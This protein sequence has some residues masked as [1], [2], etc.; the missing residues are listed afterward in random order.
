MITPL[1][2]QLR[3]PLWISQGLKTDSDTYLSNFDAIY[4][5]RQDLRKLIISC[6]KDVQLSLRKEIF[7]LTHPLKTITI[8][9]FM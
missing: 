7:D 3:M 2:I 9:I 6:H 4:C 5:M 8:Y 1:V